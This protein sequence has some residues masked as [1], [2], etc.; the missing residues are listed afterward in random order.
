MDYSF[1]NGESDIHEASI[2]GELIIYAGARDRQDQ[3]RI[4][5]T[6]TIITNYLNNLWNNPRYNKRKF[7]ISNF[8]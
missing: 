7:R 6:Q 4:N 1:V 3:N 8:V 2:G 5:H